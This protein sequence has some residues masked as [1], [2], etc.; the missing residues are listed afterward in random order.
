[1]KTPTSLQ[2]AKF[3]QTS[4]LEIVGQRVGRALRKRL[5]GPLPTHA[6][7]SFDEDV[8]NIACLRPLT[9]A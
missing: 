3:L 9:T 7:A 8:I 1:M 2:A 5:F 4:V 6:R